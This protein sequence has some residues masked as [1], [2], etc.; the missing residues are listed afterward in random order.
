MSDAGATE[1]ADKDI[2]MVHMAGSD[3]G[4]VNPALAALVLRLSQVVRTF[5][6]GDATLE[7]LRGADLDV[8]A[9]EI[10]ALTGPSGAGKS[11]LLHISG[12]LERPDAGEVE[13][14]GQACSRLSDDARTKLRRHNIGFIYQRHHLL[15]EFTAEENVTI[16]QL[17]AGTAWGE[18]RSRSKEI[19]EW[20]GLGQRL[21]HRP[22]QLSG[23]EQQRVAIARAVANIPRVL[24]AD[25]PTGNLDPQTAEDVFAM[26]VSIARTARIAVVVATHNMELAARMDRVIHFSDGRLLPGF[27]TAVAP[28]V[29]PPTEEE[30]L[31]GGDGGARFA[32]PDAA[33]APSPSAS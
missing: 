10:I 33:A 3:G 31:L 14:E 12:L 15:P 32:E 28:P 27:A 25:E 6:Q 18:A 7:V 8:A 30:A 21:T 29:A 9:G 4:A 20:L 13:I 17:I 5:H 2:P 26:L 22:G 23:G 19:L 1:A 24:L 16:P 11:T